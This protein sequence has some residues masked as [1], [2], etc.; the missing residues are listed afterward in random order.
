MNGV[1]VPANL[2][3]AGLESWAADHLDEVICNFDLRVGPSFAV[4][5]SSASIDAVLS[6]VQCP[7]RGLGPASQGQ[8]TATP[9]QVRAAASAIA[10]EEYSNYSQQFLSPSTSLMIE[11]GL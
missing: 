7:N 9:A 4:N 1:S 8:A 5:G 10:S 11:S 2:S 3:Q 6:T